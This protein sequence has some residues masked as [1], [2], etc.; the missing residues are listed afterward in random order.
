MGKA[1]QS[2]ARIVAV[3][4]PFVL[5]ESRPWRPP[6][7]VFE[8]D[9]GIHVVAEMA[10][11]A[12]DRLRL[13]VYPTSV[14]IDGRRE[15]ATPFELHRIRRLEIQSCAFQVDLPLATRVDPD[16]SEARYRDGL[17][18]IWLPFAHQPSNQTAIIHRG[19]KSGH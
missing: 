7:N 3:T 4:Q 5:F 2:A 13:H 19:E 12:V 17:L 6:L 10:G 8:T 14:R 18:D 9:Q 11:I 16:R 1:Q 15:V